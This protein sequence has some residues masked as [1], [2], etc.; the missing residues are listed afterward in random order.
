M[1]EQIVDSRIIFLRGSFQKYWLCLIEDG[2]E[3][4]AYRREISAYSRA[5]SSVVSF[6]FFCFE[7][8]EGLNW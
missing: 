3:D 2:Y 1:H 6:F 4:T 8:S 5:V 7:D